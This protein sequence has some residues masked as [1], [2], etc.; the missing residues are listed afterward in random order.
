MKTVSADL[1]AHLQLHS[2]TI[3]YLSKVKR[4]DGQIFGYTTH[5][6]QIVYDDLSGDG[7]ITYLASN[8]FTN[9]AVEGKSDLSVDNL[10]A[11]FFIDMGTES[12]ILAGVWDYA[13]FQIVVANWMDL[14]MG[15]MIIKAGNLGTISLK[16]GLGKAELRGLTNK[17][18]T[19][20]VDSYGPVCRSVFGSGKNGIDPY[21]SWPCMVDV[22]ALRQNSTIASV[23]DNATFN[24]AD[25]LS[26]VAGYFDD[27]IANF[28]SGVLNGQSFE[29]KSWDGTTIELLLE[30]PE[31]PSAG[32]SFWI[33]PGCDHLVSGCQKFNNIVNRH[34]EDF[35]PGQDSFFDVP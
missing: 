6:Q 32:D 29:I 35:I 27:G 2:T 19:Q 24:P 20:L 14:T 3:T 22:V 13:S 23:A 26:G 16:N 15:H 31:L 10:E 33:E 25:G 30:M 18:T 8:G 34:A 17:L 4:K 9:T 21:T 1:L 7:P 28:T 12:E 11:D 5:D